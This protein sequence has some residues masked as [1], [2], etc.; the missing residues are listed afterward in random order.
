MILGQ[1]GREKMTEQKDSSSPPLTKTP[2][3]QLT[4]EQPSK[5]LLERDSVIPEKHG[6]YS[7]RK[8]LDLTPD[9]P[10]VKEWTFM[11]PGGHTHN[12]EFSTRHISKD[13]KL[14]TPKF[15]RYYVFL[16]AYFFFFFLIFL[17]FQGRTCNTWTLP[18]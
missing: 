10:L 1:A 13:H 12:P 6:I 14:G 15:Q 5:K 7:V 16:C 8:H 4:A 2:N 9:L 18:G 11:E 17:S 3:L